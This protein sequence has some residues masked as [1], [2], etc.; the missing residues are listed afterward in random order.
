M[1]ELG[2]LAD[3]AVEQVR[4]WLAEPEQGRSAGARRLAELLQED[5]GLDFAVRFIDGVARPRDLWVA[6]RNLHALAERVPASLHGA[7]RAALGIGGQLG[8]VLPWVVVPAARAVLRRLVGH[9]VVDATPA[10]LGPALARLRSVPLAGAA[11]L[12]DGARQ[13][14]G[15]SS[16]RSQPR[17][18]LN[19]LGEAVLGEEEAGRRLAGIRT[20]LERPDVDYVSIKVSN[21][22][23]NL[24]MWAFDDAVTRVVQRLTPLYE[25]AA[26]GGETSVTPGRTKFINLDMEEYRDLHLT[27]AVFQ[28]LLSNPRLRQLEAG[29]V[30][31][32][33]LPDALDALEELTE[34]AQSRRAAGGAPIKVRIVK[35][36]NLAMERVDAELH[37]WPLATWGS[38][39][40]TDVNYKRMLDWALTEEHTRAVRIGVA[41]HN[42]FDIA[43]AW[44]LAGARGVRERIDFEMLLGMAT[45]AVARTTG[46]LTLYTPVVGP[47]EFDVAISYLVRRLEEN[48]SP[49][50][51]MSAMFSLREPELF[52]RERGRFLDAVERYE[53]TR[54]PVG[55]APLPNRR[56]DRAREWQD[57]NATAL[58]HPRVDP[59]DPAGQAAGDAGLTGAVLG[60]PQRTAWTLMPPER[61]EVFAP[62]L[63]A[64]WSARG[65]RETFRNAADTDPSLPANRVWAKRIL[66][67]VPGSDLG[68]AAVIAARVTD[69]A[70]LDQLIGAVRAGGVRWAQAPGNE[71]ADVLELAGL[72]LAA[73][74]DQLIEVMVA[75]TGKTLAEA[76]VE[77]SEAADFAHY[78][79][80]LAR[81]LDTVQGASFVPSALTV[82]TPPWNFPVSIPAGGVL[83][84]LAAGSGVII[85]PAPQAARCSAVM[86]D[87]L[88]RAGVPRDALALA[89][90]AEGADS[91]G[92]DLGR[93]LIG[94]ARVD[95]VILTGSYETAKLF[96]SWRPELALL[97]ETSGKNAI[98]VTPSA[99]VDLAVADIVTSA[100]GNAGQKCSAASLVILVG[101]VAEDERFRR[102][103]VDATRSLRVGSPTDPAT[104]LG[105]LIQPAEGV[106][107]DALTGLDEGE[108]WLVQPRR[109]DEEGRL[110][111]PGIKTGVAPGSRTHLTEL[112]GPVLGVMHAATLAEAIRLQNTVEY[113]LTA[114]LHSLDAREIAQWIGAVQAGNLYVNRHITGAIVQRQPFGGWK[115]S[116]VG[117][118]VKTG[119]PNTLLPLGSWKT[120]TGAQSHSLHLRGLDRD[121]QQ[122][123][124]AGQSALSYEDFDLVRRSALSDAIASA[125]EYGLVTDA[126]GL[127]VERNLFRYRPVPVSIR[128]GAGGTMAELVRVLV[129]ASVSRA[130]FDV[131]TALPLPAGVAAWLDAHS[132]PS[133]VEDDDVWLGRLTFAS[134]AVDSSAPFTVSGVIHRIRLI[135]GN[136]LAA[137]R[138]LRGDPDVAI[139]DAPVTASG[140]VELLPF[141]REQSIS[142][143]NHRFGAITGLTD[144]LL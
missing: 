68:I 6:A 102:Q 18:N 34:W 30:L 47:A 4:A 83:A 109:L 108:A 31:Q 110:W 40:D 134:V 132:V 115:R 85:K 84:A 65:G 25:L 92:H 128:L 24:S 125:T 119:G 48:G 5:G 8:P 64:E 57:E 111:S 36:A 135:G 117:T 22:V 3:A 67:R 52:E 21:I 45:D 75:E 2:D 97:A 55:L 63:P 94:D 107:L 127:G 79:A 58:F 39:L 77:V 124:E 19:L 12:T 32:A 73:N 44:G 98:V 42:L 101:S 118:T 113:G 100:F 7:F 90:I 37:G 56:Q 130:R 141:F 91:A 142:I 103:L 86:V 69:G 137:A 144:A 129:A 76:D 138:A 95:R 72:A 51:F 136:G 66:S 121:V 139:Y 53:R 131:S 60:L 106:L 33:Y 28:R 126:A 140:R 41:G 23:S 29:I 99:D 35:G 46:R 13:S 61:S 74:R 96:R 80:A 59:V 88:H 116:S 14:T 17:L 133:V 114:G 54:G 20:L 78:Y 93:E 122:L 123:I 38:K 70:K 89:D 82:V 11:R 49:D 10:R 104:Q 9:L 15:Q 62:P 16:S 120:D 50:N 26:S 81:E 87:V 105:P 71:R 1:S 143:T 112:F 27:I 43:F